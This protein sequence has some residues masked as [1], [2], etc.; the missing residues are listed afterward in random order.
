MEFLIRQ[1]TDFNLIQ[2]IFT[3]FFIIS[4][5]KTNTTKL[6]DKQSQEIHIEIEEVKDVVRWSKNGN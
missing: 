4:F 2:F 3:I 5:T 6:L 1:I